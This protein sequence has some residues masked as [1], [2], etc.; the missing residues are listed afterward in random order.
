MKIRIGFEMV[1]GCPQ[2][3][4]MI[5]NLNVHFTRASDLLRRDDLLFDPPIPVAA[6]RDS[7][8]NWCT[9]IVAPKG[10]TRVTADTTVND[11]G[12][13]D[14]I[15]PQAQQHPVQD[16]PEE[17][18]LYLFGK[19]VLRDGPLVRGRV[20][21]VWAGPN[22]VGARSGNLRFR[23]SAHCFRLSACAHDVHGT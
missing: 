13:A 22:G 17:A 18:L 12:T 21:P 3:T 20:E 10:R 4:P 15:V 16:L 8:G 6:Y 19:S 1:Y 14:E 9:R 23:P 7:F 5:F 2:P 11:S